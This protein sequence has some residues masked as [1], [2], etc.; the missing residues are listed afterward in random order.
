[1][2]ESKPRNENVHNALTKEL[3]MRGLRHIDVANIL[4]IS[5]TTVSNAISTGHFSEAK[6]RQWS[7]A[8]GIPIEVF[9]VGSEPLP[10]EAIVKLRQDVSKLQEEMEELRR[11]IN[12]LEGYTET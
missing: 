4:H 3:K 9:L 12:N 11:R 6:A 2:P 1:M 8:L 10:T 7:E 5:K